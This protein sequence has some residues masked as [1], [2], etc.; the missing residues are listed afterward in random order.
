MTDDSPLVRVEHVV[1][2]YPVGAWNVRGHPRVVHAVSDVSLSLRRGRTVGLVG[3]SGCGK[4]TL[5]RLV[6]GL[7]RPTSGVVR[8]DG[9]DIRG[10]TRAQRRT[11]RRELQL[12]FQDPYGS[13][14]PRMNIGSII[15]EPLVV[16]RQGAR[17]ERRERV[18]HLLAEVGLPASAIS[19]YPSEFSGGQR[20]RLGLARALALNPQVIVADE[21]VSAL[22]VSVRSQILNLMLDLQVAHE[23]TYLVISHDLTTLRYIAD[24]IGVMYLGKLVEWGPSAALFQNAVHPY[25]RALIGAIPVAEPPSGRRRQSTAVRGEVPSPV[26]PPS[27]CRFR[28]RCPRAESICAEVEPP[29]RDFDAGHAAACHFPL[30]DPVTAAPAMTRKESA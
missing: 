11:A 6:V 28:T 3:E 30:R 26:E 21:P 8:F 16:Q 7:E 27:G 13:L 9:V 24:E 12:M 10:G 22:D 14:D 4:S 1:R 19:R 20:Q 23:L 5:G 2:E 18:L 29:L 15:A 17:K 25:T